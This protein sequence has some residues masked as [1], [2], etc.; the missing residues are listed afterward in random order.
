MTDIDTVT[1][2]YLC[3]GFYV[4]AMLLVTF[5]ANRQNSAAEAAGGDASAV[6]Q[7]FLGGKSFGTITL[8]L[9]ALAS[10]YSGFTV[11]GVPNEAGGKD[12]ALS[13]G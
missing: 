6:S 7:H 10:V 12:T 9:T 4:C 2:V 13:G 1:P 8:T 11:V 5:I 3:L